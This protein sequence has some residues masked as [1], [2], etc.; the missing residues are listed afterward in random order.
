MN[1]ENEAQMGKAQS[2]LV[3]GSALISSRNV[4]VAENIDNRIANLR[5]QIERLEAVKEK[6]AH[7]SILDVSLEDLSMAMGRY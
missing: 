3:G 2:A 1:Y 4:T 5:E 6:L 7:G